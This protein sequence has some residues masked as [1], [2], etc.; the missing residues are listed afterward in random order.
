[1]ASCQRRQ[2]RKTMLAFAKPRDHAVKFCNFARVMARPCDLSQ[3]GVIE[4]QL[5]TTAKIR[6]PGFAVEEFRHAPRGEGTRP[7]DDALRP[8]VV[9]GVALRHLAAGYYSLGCTISWRRRRGRTTTRR[10]TTAP[11]R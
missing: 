1:M 7:R 6:A 4:D 3:A 2:G 8:P 9:G 5:G 11:R 10:G